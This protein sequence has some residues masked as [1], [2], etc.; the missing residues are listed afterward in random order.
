MNKVV[1]EILSA[2]DDDLVE[3][4]TALLELVR[5]RHY[6][7]RGAQEELKQV[8]AWMHDAMDKDD[9]HWQQPRLVRQA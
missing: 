7:K 2:V 8:T 1:R 5:E 6:D 9:T 3:L 4:A